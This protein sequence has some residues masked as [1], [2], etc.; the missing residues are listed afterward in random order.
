MNKIRFPLP[1]ALVALAASVTAA[2]ADTVTFVTPSGSTT[3]GGAVDASATFTTG[4]GV[5]NITLT[6]LQ[7]NPKDVAQAIS[8]L[9]FVLSSGATIGTLV[10]SSG[11]EVTVNGEVKNKGK[12]VTPAGELVLGSTGSTGWG[13][14]DNVKGGL[15]L[16]ALGYVGPANLLL[17]PPDG[18]LYS[19]ANSS[20]AGN[21]P[22]NPFL[23]QT[24]TFTVDVKGVTAST[25]ITGA[26]FS[27]G[28]TAGIKVAGKA[29]QVAEP[30]IVLIL[31]FD[32]LGLAGLAFV[33][34]RR[35][36]A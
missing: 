24:A 28:T 8:D 19:N 33:F 16:D 10:S 9:D 32:C 23:N 4:A 1:V 27:F 14:N 2:R 26:T 21:H 25:S 15:Q 30:S 20:I 18:P 34:R 5:I 6:N 13:L 3:S 12:V 7:G 22:H 36:K 29:V 35:F 31:G 17:G 11:Q